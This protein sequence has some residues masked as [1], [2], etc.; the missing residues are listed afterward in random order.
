MGTA[1]PCSSELTFPEPQTNSLVSR[2]SHWHGV[3][4]SM[5]PLQGNGEP[6]GAQEPLGCLWLP[7][8]GLHSLGPLPSL[9]APPD[10]REE[11]V[12]GICLGHDF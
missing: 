1:G 12:Q 3:L 11:L 7:G 8:L 9:G 10:S 2:L 5:W 6:L 4:Y